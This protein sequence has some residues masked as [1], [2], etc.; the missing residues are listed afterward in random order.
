VLDIAQ[1]ALQ[2]T[3]FLPAT[4]LPVVSHFV[5]LFVAA[6]TIRNTLAQKILATYFP[7]AGFVWGFVWTAGAI[8]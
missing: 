6:A 5:V 3:L 4:Y 8:G 7:L 2:G 1:T